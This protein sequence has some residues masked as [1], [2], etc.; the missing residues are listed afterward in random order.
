MV[1]TVKGNDYN[2]KFGYKSFKNSGI[3]KEVVSMQK[4]IRDVKTENEDTDGM[5][6]L[7]AI[8]GVF[9]ITSKLVLAALQKNHKEL[10]ADYRDPNSVKSCIDKVDD[11]L[12][13]YMEEDNAMSI[14]EL[15]EGLVEELFNNGFLSKKS[16]KL[17]T[18]LKT[19]DATVVPTDHRQS[20]N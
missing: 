16:E 9:D 20:E 18:A 11:L 1:L 19:Q 7:E 3:L 14:M 4:R 13:D 17:E 5:E 10:R 2:L 15:F 8:E 12:D 6:N